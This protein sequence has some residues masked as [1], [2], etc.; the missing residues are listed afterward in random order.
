MYFRYKRMFYDITTHIFTWKC[1]NQL[2]FE[3]KIRIAIAKHNKKNTPRDLHED[4]FL[5]R[6]TPC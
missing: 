2:Q 4:Q 3:R 5:C 6:L 1:R